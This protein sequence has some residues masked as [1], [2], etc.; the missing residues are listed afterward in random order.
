[1]EDQVQHMQYMLAA[2]KASQDQSAGGDSSQKEK[3]TPKNTLCAVFHESKNR[4]EDAFHTTSPPVHHPSVA[5][6]GSNQREATFR[7]PEQHGMDSPRESPPTKSN[8][9]G[10]SAQAQKEADFCKFEPRPT[11]HNYRSLFF[12][13]KREVARV[14]SKPKEGYQWMAEVEP[15]TSLDQVSDPKGK[16]TFDLKVSAAYSRILH[17]ELGAHMCLLGQEAEVTGEM[18]SGREIA[19]HVKGPA[20][21]PFP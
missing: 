10:E 13:V 6:Y 17:G 7:L 9:N 21:T 14:S 3:F 19:W 5:A 16:D 11:V 15:A 2:L 4:E 12:S 18:L 8:G 1:M 20:S